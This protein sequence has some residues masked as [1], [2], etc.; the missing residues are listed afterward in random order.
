MINVGSTNTLRS[1]WFSSHGDEKP[2]PSRKD[3]AT[4]TES[5]AS[6]S[7]TSSAVL[8]AADTKRNKQAESVASSSTVSYQ[9]VSATAKRDSQDGHEYQSTFDALLETAPA[10][11]TSSV[12]SLP[13]RRMMN[14]VLDSVDFKGPD[15]EIKKRLDQL[16][17]KNIVEHISEEKIT[18]LKKAA[19]IVVPEGVFSWC[20]NTIEKES[21]STRYA[22]L[23]EG[24]PQRKE[25]DK[26]LY[27]ANY[28]LREMMALSG[29]TESKSGISDSARTDAQGLINIPLTE[30]AK[31]Y[32]KAVNFRLSAHSEE[33]CKTLAHQI[34]GI[35]QQAIYKEQESHQ[36]LYYQYRPDDLYK[37][38][39]TDLNR[40]LK[41][42]TF[43][44]DKEQARDIDKWVGKLALSPEK[45]VKECLDDIKSHLKNHHAE[46][47]ENLKFAKNKKEKEPIEQD[48]NRLPVLYKR[49]QEIEDFTRIAAQKKIPLDRITLHPNP[50][51]SIHDEAYIKFPTP[52]DI[53]N[54]SQLIQNYQTQAKIHAAIAE[55]NASANSGQSA[56]SVQDKLENINQQLEK[57][58]QERAYIQLKIKE[59][60]LG[61]KREV[62]MSAKEML[63][64]QTDSAT[65]QAP[66]ATVKKD[67]AYRAQEKVRASTTAQ[68]KTSNRMEALQE[69]PLSS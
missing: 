44:Q 18:P 21:H 38:A 5:I 26:K 49:V 40:H 45:L 19:Q 6:G 39:I 1:A 30:F 28:G 11:P 7:S 36:N 66:I 67:D 61:Q 52:A 31:T 3:I 50:N 15:A 9:D 54:R 55:A 53:K 2:L 24:S 47:L 33:D 46:Q 4:N 41:D 10:V 34:N 17:G 62:L 58:E 48:I 14:K 65:S 8:V 35:V 22:Y 12:Y 56:L 68:A 37:N 27:E 43:F 51:A 59:Y 60:E 69:A 42:N 20:R 57:N 23:K 32:L 29:F 25:E 64:A 16:K 63:Q 13:P